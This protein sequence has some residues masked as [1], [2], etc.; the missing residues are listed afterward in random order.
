[1]YAVSH[2]FIHDHI[3]MVSIRKEIKKKMPQPINTLEICINVVK[4][5]KSDQTDWFYFFYKI[6]Y[7]LSL[8]ATYGPAIT[9]ICTN[10]IKWCVHVCNCLEWLHIVAWLLFNRSHMCTHMPLHEKLYCICLFET[11]ALSPPPSVS[12]NFHLFLSFPSHSLL[13]SFVMQASL[14][15]C[16]RNLVAYWECNFSFIVYRFW[17]SQ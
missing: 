11:N 9:R 16:C 14:S 5:C 4:I 6:G 12:L 2:S 13:T 17:P 10:E 15:V 7:H 1:M 8:G 3:S